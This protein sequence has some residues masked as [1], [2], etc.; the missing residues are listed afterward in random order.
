MPANPEEGTGKLAMT[1]SARRMRSLLRSTQCWHV[2]RRRA[3]KPEARPGLGPRE[4]SF[5]YDLDWDDDERL[6]EWRGVLKDAQDL[7]RSFR[8]SS[9]SMP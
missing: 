8:R 3:K 6:V 7:P 2:R 9:G 5:V 4:G 1:V